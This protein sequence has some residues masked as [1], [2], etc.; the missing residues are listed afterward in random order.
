MGT[1]GYPVDAH[2]YPDDVAEAMDASRHPTDAPGYPP[3]TPGYPDEDVEAAAET[4]S[5]PERGP[6]PP[7]GAGGGEMVQGVDVTRFL[8]PRDA[9]RWSASDQPIAHDGKAGWAVERATGKAVWLSGE[10]QYDV[11][12]RPFGALRDEPGLTHVPAHGGLPEPAPTHEVLASSTKEAR[13]KRV[14]I[15]LKLTRS[16]AAELEQAAELFG[17]T[18]TTLARLLVVRGACEIVERGVRD[19]PP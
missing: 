12:N 1:T 3:D 9:V 17:V 14:Q 6:D 15:G 13:R 10:P 8:P 4:P 5:E 19:S 18:R 11:M 7:E 2:G 16:Q